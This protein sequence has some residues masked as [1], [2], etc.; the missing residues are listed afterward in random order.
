MWNP[1]EKKDRVQNTLNY[2]KGVT[3]VSSTKL[4]AAQ[5]EVKKYP[6]EMLNKLLEMPG[7][8]Q[9][10][11]WRHGV[12]AYLLVKV[13]FEWKDAVPAKEGLNQLK[14]SLEGF[15][16]H[17]LQSKVV[18]LLKSVD[19]KLGASQLRIFNDEEYSN[20]P[21]KAIVHFPLPKPNQ[22]I[23][24]VERPGK[25]IYVDFCKEEG[26]NL[27]VTAD[28]TQDTELQGIYSDNATDCNII[29]FL[30]GFTGGT[31]DV[32]K[33]VH[34]G[35]GDPIYVKNWDE[36]RC[37]GKLPER[38]LI[39]TRTNPD[40]SY[41]ADLDTSRLGSSISATLEKLSSYGIHSNIVTIHGAHRGN[42]TFG[43]NKWGAFGS[44]R[45]GK[46]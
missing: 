14:K 11:G 30:Y 2:L 27:L 29:A 5:T 21:S 31:Y 28:F 13:L 1:I 17:A 3:G 4:A 15:A 24:W 33:L 26:S 7:D 39:N 44:T 12:R 40:T 25:W 35:G 9:T 42:G 10:K 19:D 22:G 46:F 34:I 41:L 37:N 43:V 23:L 16:E 8:K 45:T 6:H 38:I 18:D 36:V 20:T 32:I